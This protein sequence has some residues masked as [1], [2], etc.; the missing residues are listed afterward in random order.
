ME[1]RR[2]F[3]AHFIRYYRVSQSTSSQSS[4]PRNPRAG[5]VAQFLLPEASSVLENA[6]SSGADHGEQDNCRQ[7]L[8]H[9]DLFIDI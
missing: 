8:N 3:V 9:N 6:P 7:L 5:V 1:R 2:S 4:A